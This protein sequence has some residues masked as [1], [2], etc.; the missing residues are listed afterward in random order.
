MF[1]RILDLSESP[2]RL[3][4]RLENLVVEREGQP[5]T[6]IPLRELAAV[7][8]AHPQ[9][10]FTH[11]ALAGLAATGSAFVV[12]DGKR[13]PAGML[14]PVQAHFLQAERFAAQAAAG[15]ALKKRLWK[16]LVRAKVL[17][18]HRLL[19]ELGSEVSL[20]AFAERVRSGDPENL[21]AQASRR[22]W[23][24]ILGPSFRR[25]RDA[26]DANRLLN[27]GYAVLRALTARA[28]CGA[29]LHPTLGLHHRNRYDAFCLADDVMEP[30][31]PIVDRATEKLVKERGLAVPLDGQS[32]RALLEAISERFQ[33]QE[34]SRTLF[35]WLARAAVSLGEVY[36]GLSKK[37]QLPVL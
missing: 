17:A 13:L 24:Q 20:K 12:C 11:A 31:R 23:P 1:N 26:E 10:S 6:T 22:Y 7:I 30:Y 14:L 33:W 36:E 18:Q 2:A 16:Q 9:V 8:V 28:L 19:E 21:E 37:W 25:E 5:E 34:E 29:G 3:A 15:K 27:Y 35:D 32:K 4:V